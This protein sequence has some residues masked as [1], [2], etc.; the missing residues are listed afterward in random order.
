MFWVSISLYQGRLLVTAGD[1]VEKVEVMENQIN[2]LSWFQSFL[3]FNQIRNI[4]SS[5]PKGWRW[6]AAWDTAVCDAGPV[7]PDDGGSHQ[8]GGDAGGGDAGGGDD[9]GDG[10]DDDG[11]DVM[12][13]D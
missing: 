2:I 3:F 12:L 11:G 8:V 10:G 9:G 13:K 1:P 6:A 4:W 7:W 5:W